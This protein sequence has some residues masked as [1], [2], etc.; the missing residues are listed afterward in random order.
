[1]GGASAPPLTASGLGGGGGCWRGAL[2]AAAGVGVEDAAVDGADAGLLEV[3]ARWT[4]EVLGA[5]EAEWGVVRRR[6][7]RVVVNM[8]M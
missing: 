5:V 3:V 4:A 2:A 8:R 7:G 6:V 1:M